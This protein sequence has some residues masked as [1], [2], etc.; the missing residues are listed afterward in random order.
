M[1]SIHEKGGGTFEGQTVAVRKS[2]AAHRSG[3]RRRAGRGAARQLLHRTFLGAVAPVHRRWH[4]CPPA[5]GAYQ[6]RLGI[7]PASD[8]RAPGPAGASAHT[9]LSICSR[10][11]PS[12]IPRPDCCRKATSLAIWRIWRFRQAPRWP[13]LSIP[14]IRM[15]AAST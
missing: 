4:R 9:H 15:A 7:D 1:T 2:S 5:A 8:I 11:S 10:R 14:T 12:A 6:C 3:D 13:S